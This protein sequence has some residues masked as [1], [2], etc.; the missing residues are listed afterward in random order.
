MMTRSLVGRRWT[1][2]AG[3]AVA[4]PHDMS[5]MKGMSM[6]LPPMPAIYSR[7]GRQAGRAGLPRPRRPPHDR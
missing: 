3:A 7:P 5:A 6:G 4:Q 1:C 2:W